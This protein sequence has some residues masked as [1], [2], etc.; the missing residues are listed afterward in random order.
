MCRIIVASGNFDVPKIVESITL[1]ARDRNS[2]HELNKKN[3]GRW[4]HADGWGVAYLDQQGKL[5]IKKSTKAI[6]DDPTVKKLYHL[7]TNLFIVHVR[8]KAGSEV[9]I[10]NTHPFKAKHALLGECVFCHNGVIKDEIT[11]DPHYKIKGKTDSE[12]LFYSI[13]SDITENEEQK[14]AAAIRRNLQKYRQTKG[15]NVV[16]AT[17]DKTHIAMRKN[18]L[19]NYYGM[20]LGQGKDFLLISS[21][22]LK[23][24]PDISWESI[25]PGDVVTIKNGT[26]QF[27]LSKE[28][29]PLFKKIAALIPR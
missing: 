29:V 27:S 13:L 23:T 18:Q 10:K 19:P 3:Q 28:K 21:E 5:I 2:L 7:K 15:T 8:K 22:K 14:I 12:C 26:T 9:S 25:L 16:L 6:F 11:F 1:M 20:R 17:K 24:F 4:Q